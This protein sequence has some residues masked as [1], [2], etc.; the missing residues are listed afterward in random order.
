MQAREGYSRGELDLVPGD[1]QRRPDGSRR[2]RPRGER[3]DE[4]GDQRLPNPWGQFLQHGTQ[5]VESLRMIANGLRED[6]PLA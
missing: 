4:V 5:V 6:Q 3:L 2:M 1:R